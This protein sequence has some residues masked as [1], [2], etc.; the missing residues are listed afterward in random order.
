CAPPY[1][2]EPPPSRPYP[3]ARGKGKES[4]PP[5]AAEGWMGLSP[6]PRRARG[7]PARFVSGATSAS[8][9]LRRSFLALRL[10]LLGKRLALG[11]ML[12]ALA[13]EALGRRGMR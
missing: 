10:H 7:S 12:A 9:S 11:D 13:L 6:R 1:R 3:A 5:L 2:A 8:K 4:L